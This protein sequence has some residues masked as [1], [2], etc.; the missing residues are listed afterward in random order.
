MAVGKPMVGTLL[1]QTIL[2]IDRLNDR[3]TQLERSAPALMLTAAEEAHQQAM[4]AGYAKGA[5]RSLILLGRAELR[6]GNLNEADRFLS[7]AQSSDALDELLQAQIFNA[8]GIVYLYL[9]IWDKAFAFYQQGLSLAKSIGD[10]GL[11]ARL[12]NNIGEIYREHRDFSTALEYY[13]AS[14]EAQSGLPEFRATAVPVSNISLAYFELGDL[15]QSERYAVEAFRI[16]QQ[17]ND[18]MIQST[19][20]RY[21]AIIARKR[22]QR[23]QAIQYLNASLAIYHNTREMLHAALALLEFHRVY[24]EEGNIEMSLAKLREA[25]T[26]AEEAD[27]LPTRV[28]IYAELARVHESTGDIETALLYH[29]QRLQAVETME[30]EARQQRLRA[31]SV[32]IAADESYREK[33]AYRVLSQQLEEKTRELARLSNRDGLTN[34]ANRRHFDE[35]LQREWA[36]ALRQQQQVSLLMMDV[37][38]LKE[39]N[40]TYGHLA[41]DEV[42]KRIAVAMKQSVKRS[43]DLV[44]R[45]GGDEFVVLLA[46]TDVDGAMHV[47]AEI[48]AAVADCKIT[49]V[50][51]AASAQVTLSIGI[52]SMVPSRETSPSDLIARGDRA[53]YQAKQ[54]GRDRILVSRE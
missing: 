10:R 51:S 28:E 46:D 30:Q 15:E 40:D 16:A 13:N 11:E 12:L 1:M 31:F 41:G 43:T 47:A 37:D 3:A 53:L 54:A 38:C 22:G 21:R 48:Q 44:A 9:K 29:K 36:V 27:S 20:L 50:P 33:E 19:A 45:Y 6:L 26:I 25:M 2:D 14:L 49:Q 24:F 17:K 52:C 34:I 4:A 23:A 18:Q 35:S 7:L 5:A 39:Y 8:R 42:I 32:Q